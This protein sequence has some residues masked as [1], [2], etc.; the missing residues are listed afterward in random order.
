MA[1]VDPFVIPIPPELLKDPQTREFFEYFV[2]WAHDI[3]LRTG[4]G[5]DA[6][7]RLSK[8]A[9]RQDVFLPLI[10]NKVEL[11]DPVT[12]DDTGFTVDSTVLYTDI[13]LS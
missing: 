1:R 2:R 9:T 8:D 4:G 7:D 6:V 10:L 5:N 13:T 11:G 12:V 3:W